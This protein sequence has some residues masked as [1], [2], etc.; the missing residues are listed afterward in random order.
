MGGIKKEKI[1][2]RIAQLRNNNIY[3]TRLFYLK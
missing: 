1:T 3:K 2:G